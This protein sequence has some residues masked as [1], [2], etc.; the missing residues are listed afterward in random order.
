M[1]LICWKYGVFHPKAGDL[2]AAGGFHRNWGGFLTSTLH[3]L[4]SFPT[5]IVLRLQELGACPTAPSTLP[6]SPSFILVV[7][8][9]EDGGDHPVCR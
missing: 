8:W 3:C 7:V 9:G 2:E 1:C 6:K 5:G 4:L